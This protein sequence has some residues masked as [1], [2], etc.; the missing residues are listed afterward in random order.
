MCEKLLVLFYFKPNVGANIHQINAMAALQQQQAFQNHQA[1]QQHR[2]LQAL[3][4]GNISKSAFNFLRRKQSFF[5]LTKN[6]KLR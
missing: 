3:Q 2:Q 6:S 5:I 4:Q 1:M